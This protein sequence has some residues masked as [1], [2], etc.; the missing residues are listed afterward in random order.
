VAFRKLSRIEPLGFWHRRQWSKSASKSAS[1]FMDSGVIDIERALD[2]VADT[3]HIS[4]NPE[5]YLLVPARAVSADRFNANRDGF[6]EDE[7]LRFDPELGR[8]V[9]QSFELKPHFVNHQ[10]SNPSVAR[11]CVLD[12]HFNNINPADDLVKRAVFNDCA[13]DVSTDNFVELLIAV[14]TTKDPTLSEGYKSGIVKEFSMGADV[15]STVCSICGNEAFNEFQFCP[16][17]RGKFSGRK[18]RLSDGRQVEA[19]EWCKGTRYAEISAV[20]DPAD[21]SAAI[22]EGL[23]VVQEKRPEIQIKLSSRDLGEVVSYMVRHAKEMPGA[24]IELVNNH[25]SNN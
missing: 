23:L 24:L 1:L 2:V 20:D 5:D 17:V 19:G 9:Y 6:A 18:H 12:V 7:L 14:D 11:G 3:Y 16:C 22:Q 8:R 25:L 13:K 10:S 15:T 21:K 4:R